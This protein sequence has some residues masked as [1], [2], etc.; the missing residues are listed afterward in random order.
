MFQL[1]VDLD[2]RVQSRESQIKE[3][4]AETESFYEDL[5]SYRESN[6][7]IREVIADLDAETKELKE[8]Y[9]ELKSAVDEARVII[10]AV[11]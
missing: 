1:S 9:E 4:Q 7:L 8:K 11:Q 2:A 3:L 6:E 5:I 10:E